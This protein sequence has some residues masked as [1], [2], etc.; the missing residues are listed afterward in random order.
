MLDEED[1]TV[2]DSVEDLESSADRNG[3]NCS[4][5]CRSKTESGLRQSLLRG[6]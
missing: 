4:A 5:S 1:E 3:A 6:R 2:V